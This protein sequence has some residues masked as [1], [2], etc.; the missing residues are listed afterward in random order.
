MRT[1]IV[2][3]LHLGSATGEDLGRDPAIRRVLLEEIRAA[4]RLVLLG[5][6]VELRELPLAR[7]AGDSS[8]PSSRSWARR[9]PA[10]A[11]SSS[12][13][14]TTTASPSRCSRRSRSAGSQLG[15]EHRALPSR[16]AGSA[17]RR[18]ARRCRAQH[19]L[20]RRMAAR[21]RLRHPRP[22]HGLPHEP[23]AAGVRRRGG[24]HARR[25]PS[26]GPR[27]P[28]PTTSASCGRST[29]SPSASPRPG[30][31]RG[32][33]RPSERA[34]RSISGRRRNG[35][36]A[37]R[38]SVKAAVAAG[39]PASV[40]LLNR[41]LPCRLRRR[42]LPRLD[43]PQRHRRRHR[44]GAA[45]AGRGRPH[46]HRPHPPRRPRRGRGGV[47]ATGWRPPAQ[48]RQLGLRRRLPPPRHAAGPLLAGNGHLGRGRGTAAPG[49]PAR[50]AARARS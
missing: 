28:R 34:W 10:A 6:V 41:A 21:R 20:P 27:H 7:R 44:A 49:A 5:D 13:A 4:D 19:R 36:R 23:A 33:T 22:L 11:S 45:A 39:I 47:A 29:A 1:A 8:G 26:A 3:D 35:G 43:H 9:W 12:P 15:L 18:L 31:A 38:T 50:R 25:R 46:D 40:W 30:L 2:S 24:D 42:P 16:R 48:H 14:T 32:A 17:D 37:R